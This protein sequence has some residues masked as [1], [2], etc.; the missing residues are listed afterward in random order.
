MTFPVVAF[1]TQYLPS[2]LLI[3]QGIVSSLLGVQRPTGILVLVRHVTKPR[4]LVNLWSL[5]F[6]R[7]RCHWPFP[8]SYARSAQFDSH[9]KGR[10]TFSTWR[11]WSEWPCRSPFSYIN[12][13]FP[14]W[15][16]L[17]SLHFCFHFLTNLLSRL[18]DMRWLRS[19]HWLLLLHYA[20]QMRTPSQPLVSLR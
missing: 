6:Y 19:S 13:E 11:W 4:R 9:R 20:D 17:W 12:R 14:S 10:R 5:A 16:G 15:K 1:T 2:R 8:I 18:A 7:N 3:F